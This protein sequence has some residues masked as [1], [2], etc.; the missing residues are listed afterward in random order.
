M[1]AGCVHYGDKQHVG[2]RLA[3]ALRSAVYG[4][5]VVAVGP[6]VV[7]VETNEATVVV[8]YGPD[9]GPIQV[10]NT[11]GFELSTD[12]V[13]Y[14]AALIVSHTD[15]SITLSVPTLL[16]TRLTSARG[17]VVSMRCV[18]PAVVSSRQWVCWCGRGVMVRATL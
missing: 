2:S 8:E 10:R 13:H 1:V 16:R 15:S 12:G 5:D 4:H 6:M 18:R 11:S 3:L 14:T 9:G 7:G 17:N